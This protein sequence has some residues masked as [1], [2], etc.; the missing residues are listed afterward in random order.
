MASLQPVD[1]CIYKSAVLAAG[2]QFN[3]PPGAILVA[4]SDSTAITSNC[5]IDAL[6]QLDCYV[7]II[8]TSGQR[9]PTPMNLDYADIDGFYY[10]GIKTSFNSPVG[11][12]YT[13]L[14]NML[15]AQLSTT[16]LAGALSDICRVW[17]DRSSV[18]GECAYIFF[19]TIPSIANILTF[20]VG[21]SHPGNSATTPDSA[22]PF[23]LEYPVFKVSEV[24]NRIDGSGGNFETARCGC[25][26]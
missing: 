2:E 24:G 14:P 9:S 8:P 6:E 25:A 15:Q 1:N 11:T 19:K 18:E 16:A 4:A 10:N 23:A 20:S 13:D 12:S 21:G 3:L 5:P 22:G 7:V 17:R 26:A